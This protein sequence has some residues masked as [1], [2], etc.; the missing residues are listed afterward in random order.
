MLEKLRS[1]NA[2]WILILNLVL[3]F[4]AVGYYA[5]SRP[6][7]SPQLGQLRSLP[8]RL[9]TW[10]QWQ[11][12]SMT[13][14]SLRILHPDDYL[15]RIYERE[16]D[17]VQ[18]DVYIAYFRSQRSGHGPH[19]PQNCLPGNGWVP[20]IREKILIPVDQGK[21]IEVNRIL[22]AKGEQRSVV[23]YWYQ[24]PSRVVASEYLA[25]VQLVLDSV[26]YNRSD[27]T[28]LRVVVPLVSGARSEEAGKE[29]VQ[30]IHQAV[31]NYIPMVNDRSS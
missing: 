7:D 19:S 22:V 12:T 1:R 31:Q 5:F 15:L 30:R 11:E 18:A 29:L 26:R 21:P 10:Y 20:E 27:T 16:T 23:F 25:R 2:I 28:L 8:A 14:E 17:G 6:E 24:A 3:V 9:G 4:Q 13:P